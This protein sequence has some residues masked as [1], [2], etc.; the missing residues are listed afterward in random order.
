MNFM[1]GHRGAKRTGEPSPPR[2]AEGLLRL[3]LPPGD[4]ETV[5]GDLLEEYR[6]A[7][8][9]AL[10]AIRADL[11]YI[12]HVVSVFW[13]VIRPF[14]LTMVALQILF[15]ILVMGGPPGP[16]LRLRLL[17]SFWYG[18]MVQAP[19][20]SLFDALIYLAAGYYGA[21]R[22]LLIRTGILASGATGFIGIGALFVELAVRT[23]GLLL[24]PLSKPFILVIEATLLLLA[25]GY[26]LLLGALAAVVGKWIPHV[27]SLARGRSA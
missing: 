2:W 11:W 4:R 27:S 1:D 26:A 15:S 12:K 14:V 25:V 24:A 13:R 7:R 16:G 17:Q 21:R 10:G 20:I 18:S 22:T 9:P 8:H 5:S 19:G 3:S 6:A 23:P